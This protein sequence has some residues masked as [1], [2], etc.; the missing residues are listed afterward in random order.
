VRIL[1]LI[2]S[3]GFYGAE[4][5]IVTLA[6]KLN[7][8]GH[9]TCIGVF[10]NF[11]HPN[12]EIA[13]EAKVRNLPVQLIPC[14]GRLDCGA[15][16][17]LRALLEKVAPEMLH[18]HGYKA[19]VYGYL[20]TRDSN[21]TR[22]STCHTWHDNDLKD[23]LYGVL[24][25]T[26]LRRFKM[27]VAVSEAVA[28]RLR[29]AGVAAASIRIITNGIDVEEF[30]RGQ[31]S[32]CADLRPNERLVGLVGRLAPEKG[33]QYFLEA[34]PIVLRSYPEV[35][36]V[37]IGDGPERQNLARTARA[38]GI[39]ETVRFAGKLQVMPGVYAS[40]DILVSSSLWEGLPMTIL[41]ALAAAIPVIATAVGAVPMVVLHEQTGLLVP[42][43]DAKAL[44]GGIIR[45]LQDCEL[46]ER[47]ADQGNQL[48]RQ[49][50]SAETMTTQYLRLYNE[51][52]AAG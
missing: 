27:T 37:V 33:I 12:T 43:A 4:R 8:I 2:S 14:D 22:I 35:R 11:R 40:L 36:F 48:V 20:A 16:R 10:H 49:Q 19:D 13:D 31:P 34:V 6:S 46:R 38:L 3:G 26:V 15:V 44:A 21:I 17:T 51:L 41:E 39:E 28:K 29:D 9:Q 23:Y 24:D 42:A 50:F 18:T 30:S 47:L 25:R 5:V 7:Q 45:L 1:H 32:L 52:R